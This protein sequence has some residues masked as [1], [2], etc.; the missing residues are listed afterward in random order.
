MMN[1]TSSEAPAPP[2]PPAIQEALERFADAGSVAEAREA[3]APLL[4]TSGASVAARSP[5]FAHGLH[6]LISLIVK[7]G[8]E[9]VLGLS[10]AWRLTSVTSMRKHRRNLLDSLKA[11]IP[12]FDELPT[13][14][15]DPEDRRHFGDAMRHVE[16]GWLPA[17]LA[18]AIVGER[19][20]ERARL[21]LSI[22]FVV[23][24]P[25]HAEQL[26]L[27]LVEMRDVRF[28]QAEPG[29]GR[30]RRLAAV[31]DALTHA[32]WQSESEEAPGDD[33]GKSLAELVAWSLLR[34]PIEDRSVAVTSAKSVMSYLI[35]IV[36]LH[37]TLAA[38]ARTYEVLSPLRRLFAPASW[39]DDLRELLSRAAKQL[40]E[41]LVFLVRLGMPD[42]ELRRTFIALLG[43]VDGGIRLRL[44]VEGDA[45]LSAEGAHW[46]RTGSARKKLSTQAAIE[47]TA[48]AV[49]DHDVGLAY[50]E[51]EAA[52]AIATAFG[53]E[54]RSAADFVSPQ[55]GEEARDLLSRLDRL[56]NHVEAAARKRG[57]TLRGD[58]GSVVPFVPNEHEPRPDAIGERVVRV[59]SRIVERVSEGRSVGIVVKAD[60]ER[61]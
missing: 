35:T 53:D 56:C 25:V 20:A 22:A 44:L 33:F 40:G 42:A 11:D 10:L 45:S 3:A 59:L 17:Y 57:M 19:D 23:A 36:R 30:A 6:R 1:E 39:P 18:A 12:H 9:R 52:A 15:A 5:L 38:E 28:D 41:Q 49:I 55:V 51:A 27:L 46:L 54:F 48:V 16:G 21:S 31:L 61:P 60:V 58:L 43:E 34:S 4:T 47:E 29:V 50:R 32:S 7:G 13:T 2:V 37:G 24:V 26:K 14:M 8:N